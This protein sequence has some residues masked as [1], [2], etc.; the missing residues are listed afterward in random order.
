MRVSTNMQFTLATRTINQRQGELLRVQEQ[1][2]TGRRINSFAEDPVASRKVLREQGNLRTAESWRRAASNAQLTLENSESVLIGVNTALQRAYEL[3]IQLANDSFGDS[4]RDSAADEIVQIRE[5]IVGLANAER[6]GRYLFSGLGNVADPFALD[7]TF[8]GDTGRLSVPVGRGATL[9][10]VL[11]GGEPFLDPAG[12][13]NTI[14]SL[15]ELEDA[16]RSDD[17]ARLDDM[18][19]EMRATLD[20]ATAARQQIGQRL[21]RLDV[22]NDA[23]QRTETTA[24]ATLAVERDTDFNEAVIRLRQSETGL[25]AALSITGR[26]DDLSLL[27]FL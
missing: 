13:R 1:L 3:N 7:G 25:Q 24:N 18:I 2:A 5:Q 8:S 20:R 15:I 6:N 19:D 26:L 23:L 27:N 11:G 21:I 9:D 16:L 12:G 10:A 17:S 22:V 4:D 14:E